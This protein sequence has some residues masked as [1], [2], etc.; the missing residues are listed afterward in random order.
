MVW[1]DMRLRARGLHPWGLHF[2]LGYAQPWCISSRS[3]QE[4]SCSKNIL[5][6]VTFRTRKVS[7]LGFLACSDTFFAT[8]GCGFT[9]RV[10]TLPNFRLSS[11]N[12]PPRAEYKQKRRRWSSVA[13]SRWEYRENHFRVFRHIRNASQAQ[14]LA[15]SFPMPVKRRATHCTVTMLD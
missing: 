8:Q 15:F 3:R 13:L 10:C 6:C 7:E 12:R 14:G 11:G 5:P 2:F 9:S 1:S 4:I